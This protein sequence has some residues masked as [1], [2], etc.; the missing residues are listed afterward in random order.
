[1]DLRLHCVVVGVVVE[2][3]CEPGRHE[4]FHVMVKGAEVNA[5]LA[6]LILVTPYLAA[7][8]VN[9]RHTMAVLVQI[10]T[11]VD[12]YGQLNRFPLASRMCVHAEGRVRLQES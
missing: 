2:R 4:S 8:L 3:S 7:A 12:R 9:S 5:D 1:M 11:V 6:F 10:A